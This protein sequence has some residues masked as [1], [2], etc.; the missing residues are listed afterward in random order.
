MFSWW[1]P[2]R[3]PQA[4]EFCQYC[5]SGTTKVMTLSGCAWHVCDDHVDQAL[6]DY[7]KQQ[8]ARK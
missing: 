4:L 6:D 2:R 8:E 3:L 7:L 1:K 5:D